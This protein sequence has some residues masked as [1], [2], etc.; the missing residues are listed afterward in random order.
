M[1]KHLDPDKAFPPEVIDL[2]DQRGIPLPTWYSGP[3]YTRNGDG[4]DA[5][6]E[7]RAEAEAD[8]GAPPPQSPPPSGG[9]TPA[10]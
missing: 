8:A 5:A 2:R 6:R 9:G 7:L 4:I 3:L 10:P 1:T